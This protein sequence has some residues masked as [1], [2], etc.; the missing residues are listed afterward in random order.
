MVLYHI[1]YRMSLYKWSYVVHVPWNIKL[2]KTMTKLTWWI[3]VYLTEI[4]MPGVIM[5]HLLMDIGIVGIVIR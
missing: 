5:Q 1:L 2:V 3:T 4:S